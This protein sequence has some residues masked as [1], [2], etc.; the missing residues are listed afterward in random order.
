LKQGCRPER[1]VGTALNI[2]ISLLESAGGAGRGSR[3]IN[4]VG[5]AVT[6]GPGKIVDEKLSEK[7]R[8]HLDI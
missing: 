6:I 7:I 1:C 2:A 3:I 5:G 8:S 4:L